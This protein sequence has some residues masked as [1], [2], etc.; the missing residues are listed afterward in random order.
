MGTAA[1]ETVVAHLTWDGLVG[2]LLKDPDR[3]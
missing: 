3:V 2:T 1:R